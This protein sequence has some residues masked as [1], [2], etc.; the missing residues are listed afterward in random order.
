LREKD[1][2]ADVRRKLAKFVV[3]EAFKSRSAVVL[4]DLPRNTPEHMVKGREG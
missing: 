2:K 3:V 1:K 4:E